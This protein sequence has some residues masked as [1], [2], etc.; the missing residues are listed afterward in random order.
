MV[1]K[2]T[3]T[4]II[5]NSVTLMKNREP[6]DCMFLVKME[7]WLQCATKN[8]LNKSEPVYINITNDCI[9]NTQHTI[10]Y[11]YHTMYKSVCVCE[12]SKSKGFSQ[13]LLHGLQEVHQ[14]SSCR[15]TISVFPQTLSDQAQQSLVINVFHQL[16]TMLGSWPLTCVHLH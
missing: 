8:K 12:C 11:F 4:T 6:K 16:S 5:I 10:I 7:G 15:T 3:Y 2:T 1:V 13:S 9:K 14:L